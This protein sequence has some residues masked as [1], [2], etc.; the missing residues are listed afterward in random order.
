MDIQLE[1]IALIKLLAETENPS[2]INEIKK[3]FQRE[4]KDWWEDLSE[5]QKA[6]IEEGIKDADEGKVVSYEYFMKKFL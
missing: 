4:K 6:D 3:V 5:E 1:K 2:I